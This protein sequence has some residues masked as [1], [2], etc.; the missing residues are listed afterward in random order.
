[1]LG[2]QHDRALL[3]LGSHL[4]LHGGQDVLGRCDV[5]DLVTHH[6]HAPGAG[7]LVELGNDVRVDDAASLEGAV[8]LDLADFAPQCRLGELRDGEAV[9]RNAIRGEVRVEHLHI[10]DG[11][12]TNLHVVPRDADLLGDVE[13]LLFQTVSVSN[14]LDERNQDMKPGLQRTAVL[15]EALDDV[16]ALLRNYGRGARDHDYDHNGER[17]EN[18]RRVHEQV[19]VSCRCVV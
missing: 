12:N 7:G 15:A 3:A 10:Q 19:R 1:S 11:V 18:V 6:F 9:V 14:A 2:C 17:D 13:R 16:C 8:E 4:L 5:L